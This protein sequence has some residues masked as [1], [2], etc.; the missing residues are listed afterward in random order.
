MHLF[1]L[2]SANLKAETDKI[3]D[4]FVKLKNCFD[5]LKWTKFNWILDF[6]IKNKHLF[7]W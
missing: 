6:S 5:R 2:K 4:S 7:F 1:D 3:I